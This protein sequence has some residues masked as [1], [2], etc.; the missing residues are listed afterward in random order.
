MITTTLPL[1]SEQ[2][3]TL[4]APD[5]ALLEQVATLRRENAALRAEN[6]ALQERVREL[7]AR[8]GQ[9]AANSSWPPRLIRPRHQ[10]G[11]KR[12]SPDGSAAASP[13]TLGPAAGCCRLSG[14]TKSCP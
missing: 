8:L 5:P 13:D 12:G 3:A 14:W 7:E 4:P 10:R 11:R 6:A 1:A 2:W 9:N